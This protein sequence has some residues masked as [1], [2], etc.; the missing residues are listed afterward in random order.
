MSDDREITAPMEVADLQQG[1]EGKTPSRPLTHALLRFGAK[2]DLG[3]VRENNE[4]KFDFIEPD[5]PVVLARRGRVYAVADGMGGHSAGQIASELG[6]KVFI[7]SYYEDGASQ[8]A[9][10][11]KR[12]VRDAN[13]YIVE[14]AR[15][16]PG[17]RG[18]GT[19]LT[20]AVVR[21]DDMI[22]TQVGDSRLY[23]VRG[24]EIRQITQDHSWV[25]E[26]VRRGT[27]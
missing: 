20:A 15:A 14:V 3:Q 19:T 7:R 11:L 21:E 2:T 16:I 26:H 25:A 13:A 4:D 1:W 5:D 18:I 12:A 6:L 23:Q 10:A 27:M 17:R 24:G 8:A 9:H 22:I